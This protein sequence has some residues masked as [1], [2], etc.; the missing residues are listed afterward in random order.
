MMIAGPRTSIAL[1]IF[2]LL[3]L[4]IGGF[5]IS[6]QWRTALYYPANFEDNAGREPGEAAVIIKESPA[7]RSKHIKG[8]YMNEYAANSKSA[9]AAAIRK[10]IDD[11]LSQ[12]ELNAVVIDIKEADG[13]YLPASLKDYIDELR[14]KDVWVIARICSFRDSSLIEQYPEWY[15][16]TKTATSSLQ[17]WQDIAGGKWLDPKN[18]GAQNYLVEFSKKA[19]DFGFDELQFDYIRFPSE[20]SVDDV[21]YPFYDAKKEEKYEV[22]AAFFNKISQELREYDSD[23]I[24]SADLFGYVAAHQNAPEI[25]QRTYDASQSFDYISYMLYPSHFY[26]GLQ[27]PPDEKRGLPAMN[28]PYKSDDLSEVISNNPYSVIARSIFLA[29]D[30]IAS[31]GSAAKIRPWLQDFNISKDTERGIYYD[32]QKVRQ[33]ILAAEESGASGWLL[34]NASVSYTK[35]ALSP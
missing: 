7:E 11:L 23:I 34:W 9:D 14:R 5:F 8:V 1:F 28:L 19:I 22:I 33:Q 3:A 29:S 20:G 30:Y 21:I 35:S 10:E 32:A 6:T 16:W 26:S 4:S 12:T 15:L 2:P 24:L 18:P 13:P 27:V 25:G 17:I 31:V